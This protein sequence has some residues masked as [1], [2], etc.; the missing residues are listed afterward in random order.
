MPMDP[1]LRAM[2]DE[3]CAE[4]D[5]VRADCE[6]SEWQRRRAEDERRAD[7]IRRSHRD[8]DAW[9]YL[10]ELTA[11]TPQPQAAQEPQ[12]SLSEV[13]DLAGEVGKV[14]GR[15]ERQ[16][17][18]LRDRVLKLEVTNDIL[19]GFITSGNKAAATLTSIKG[20]ADAA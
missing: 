5:Q 16:L 4:N 19:R 10:P 14:T 1:D 17:N 11:S 3:A 20:G 12:V 18:E 7:L 13:M 2:I 6:A 15:L 9:D 8:T